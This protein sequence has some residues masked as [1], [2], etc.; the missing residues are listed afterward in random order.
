V[1]SEKA[2]FSFATIID[3]S[4]H[5]EYNR[6]H[7]LDH[8]PENLLLDG[9]RYGERWV[10]TPDCAAASQVNQPELADIHY[11]N[12]YWFRPPALQSIAEWQALAERSFQWGRRPESEWAT[13]PLMGF[14]ST[15]KG[16]ATPRVKVSADALPFRP[17]RGVHITVARVNEPHGAEASRLYAWYDEVRIPDLLECHGVAGVWSF[18]SDSTTLDPSWRPVPGSPTFNA[19]GSDQGSLRIML[20][21]LDEDVLAA[22]EAMKDRPRVLAAA[23]RWHDTSDVESTLFA[24]PLMAIIPWQWDWFGPASTKSRPSSDGVEG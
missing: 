7:Q 15:V 2:F 18:S 19:S 3:D 22:C 10:L 5:V 13:R 4:K 16:Y 9:V 8:R 17:N 21:F 24:A 14:F 11:V 1:L 23:G 12:S 6:W 20:A